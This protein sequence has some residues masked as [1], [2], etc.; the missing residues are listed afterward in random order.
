MSRDWQRVS[1][2]KN[3][4]GFRIFLPKRDVWNAKKK[5][6]GMDSPVHV[7][8]HT[9]RH[10]K[11]GNNNRDLLFLHTLHGD[12][13]RRSRG[14]GAPRFHPR[15]R[16][17]QPKGVRVLADD[18]EENERRG[19]EEMDTHARKTRADEDTHI[20]SDLANRQDEQV[21]QD[22]EED[23]D[24]RH[25]DQKSNGRVD[26]LL[27][28]L[29]DLDKHGRRAQQVA[30]REGDDHDRKQAFIGGEGVNDIVWDHTL[31][32]LDNDLVRGR[33]LGEVRGG[34]GGLD[35]ARLGEGIRAHGDEEL[36]AAQGT[37][38]G[39]LDDGDDHETHVIA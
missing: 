17:T 8:E 9:Q 28:L 14:S 23:P 36:R 4:L 26:E 15:R 25:A 33:L 37:G 13:Q 3:S 39:A 16:D 29:G 31:K 32:D 5:K 18:K 2:K 35:F 11:L 7:D 21:G 6:K 27:H 19:D 38:H 20:A 30:D 10:H 1:K 22:E 34:N 12:R 24:G